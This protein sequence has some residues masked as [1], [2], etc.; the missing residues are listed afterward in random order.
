MKNL[1]LFF[2]LIISTILLFSCEKQEVASE[3]IQ[4]NAL[5]KELLKIKSTVYESL[6]NSY[7]SLKEYT[8]SRGELDKTKVLNSLFNTE[9]FSSTSRD[10][11]EESIKLYDWLNQNT[12]AYRYNT[13]EKEFLKELHA[14][15][16]LFDSR[17]IDYASYLDNLISYHNK[18]ASEI[19]KQIS[20]DLLKVYASVLPYWIENKAKWESLSNKRAICEGIADAALDAA[21]V[22]CGSGALFGSIGGPAGSLAACLVNAV[23]AATGITL[24]KA[25]KCVASELL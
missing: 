6:D 15:L 22:G 3:I 13:S 8:L 20:L 25:I 1:A 16:D 5:K 9:I 7:I 18:Y 2:I 10:Q 12:T 24:W 21:I 23:I 4:T 17:L 14:N 11:L 19:S